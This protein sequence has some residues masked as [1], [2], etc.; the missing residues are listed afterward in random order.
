[1]RPESSVSVRP[2]RIWEAVL[3]GVGRILNVLQEAPAVSWLSPSEE[4]N[5]YIARD[6][7][8]CIVIYMIIFVTIVKKKGNLQLIFDHFLC[9]IFLKIKFLSNLN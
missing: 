2:E 9:Y 3:G 4:N 6:I 5:V 8:A 7:C 1:M